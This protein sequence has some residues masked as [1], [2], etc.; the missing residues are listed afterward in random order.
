VG[1]G[2]GR[3]GDGPKKVQNR[4][5]RAMGPSRSLN[6]EWSPHLDGHLLLRGAAWPSS[7]WGATGLFDWMG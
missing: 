1:P 4:P 3:V 6:A 2:G 5:E 7:V